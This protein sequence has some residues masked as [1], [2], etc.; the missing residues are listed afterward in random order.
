MFKGVENFLGMP[1]LEHAGY[2]KVGETSLIH[3]FGFAVGSF[4]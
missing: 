3:C 4:L 1:E 2:V